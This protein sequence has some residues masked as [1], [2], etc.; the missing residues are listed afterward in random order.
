M[1]SSRQQQMVALSST[2]AEYVAASEATKDIIWLTKLFSEIVEFVECP[3]LYCD[4]QG[5]IALVE[6]PVFHKRT[7][8]IN[9]KYHFIRN[10][11]ADKM[12]QIEYVESKNQVA[13]IF[14]KNIKS[15]EL[16]DSLRSKLGMKCFI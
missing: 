12:L 16:F 2:E 10:A 8:H 13:D 1:W 15:K 5:A 14:T 9:V 3:K 4:N 11:C 7:K 6:N